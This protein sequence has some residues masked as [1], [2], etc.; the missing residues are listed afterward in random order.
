MNNVGSLFSKNRLLL[1]ESTSGDF[2][3][4]SVVNSLYP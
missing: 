3:V 2:A 1:I 4:I